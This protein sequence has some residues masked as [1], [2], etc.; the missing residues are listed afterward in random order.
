MMKI[1]FISLIVFCFIIIYTNIVAAESKKQIN[2]AVVKI[3]ANNCDPSL[4]IAIEELVIGKLYS[5]SQFVLMEK[6]QIDRIAQRS[7]F[8]DFDI[9]D[10]D[11]MAK[12]GQVLKVDKIIVGSIS[13]IGKYRLDIRSIDVLSGKIELSVIT[14]SDNEDE[15][16]TKSDESV[17]QIER[18]YLGNSQISGKFDV[19]FSISSFYPRGK[20][21]EYIKN[22]KG[23]FASFYYNK[24]FDS[25]FSACLSAGIYGSDGKKEE[26]QSL[27]L[28]PIELTIGPVYKISK[29]VSFNPS[30]GIGFIYSKLARD[31]DGKDSSGNYYYT[32]EKLYNISFLFRSEISMLVYDRFSV[33]ITPGIAILPEPSTTTYYAELRLGVKASF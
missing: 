23:G 26:I 33:Y 4:G 21:S 13:K 11:L 3:Q 20:L 25:N 27:Y 1:K 28:F 8:I 6:S 17:L 31:R 19:S 29:A 7:G 16:E 9:S 2:I 14:E 10:N 24:I 30:G 15:I 32:T 18:Y 5:N 12:L 22:A